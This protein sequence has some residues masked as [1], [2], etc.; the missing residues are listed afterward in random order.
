MVFFKKIKSF[1]LIS[2]FDKNNLDFLCNLFNKYEIGIISSGSTSKKIRSLELVK[3]TE[4]NITLI[5]Y[6]NILLG[7]FINIDLEPKYIVLFKSSK[8][9]K[10]K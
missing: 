3:Y 1:A 2:V 4:L 8:I 5:D 7:T 9:S 10:S 6:K